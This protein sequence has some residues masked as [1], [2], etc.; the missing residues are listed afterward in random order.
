MTTE[1]VEYIL[2]AKDNASSVIRKSTADMELLNHEIQQTAKTSAASSDA[3]QKFANVVGAGWI[4]DGARQAKELAEGV[5][6][7]AQALKGGGASALAMKAG[8]A[9]ITAVASY[10][11]GEVIAGWVFETKKFTEELTKSTEAAKLLGDQMAAVAGRRIDQQVKDLKEFGGTFEQQAKAAQEIVKQL[12]VEISGKAG[13]EEYAKA[14]LEKLES[15]RSYYLASQEEVDN[16]RASLEIIQDSK[17]VMQERRD[18]L[19]QEYS[20]AEAERMRKREAIEQEKQSADNR[21]MIVKSFYD[22]QADMAKQ[23]KQQQEKDLKELQAAEKK[24]RDEEIKASANSVKSL[25]KEISDLDKV[26]PDSSRPSLTS[27]DERMTSLARGGGDIQQ[28]IAEHTKR[29]AAIAVRQE[30]LQVMMEKHLKLIAEK[31][32]KVIEFAGAG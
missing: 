23:F 20:E 30:K 19:Q 25:E 17:R 22:F 31:E 21:K 14:Q 5:K 1:S 15:Q 24:K 2:S 6:G 4:T 26:K 18:I 10:K 13:Q 29:Q 32:E 27:G 11:I 28:Q 12:N 16:A 8:L 9:G 3:L 7:A